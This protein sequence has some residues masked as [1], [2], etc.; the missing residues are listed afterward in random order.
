M[1]LDQ[2]Q[3]RAWADSRAWFPS[4]HRTD[5]DAMVHFALGI[6]GEVGELVN[7]I[8]KINRSSTT[9]ANVYTELCHEVADVL[10]YLCDLAEVL[11]IDLESAVN[12]KRQVLIERWGDPA[13]GA[14][15]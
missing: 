13:T 3:Q 7:L 10:I 14:A 15:S 2:L 4:V 8:K 12:E 9:V 5:H 11:N 1:N 6:A